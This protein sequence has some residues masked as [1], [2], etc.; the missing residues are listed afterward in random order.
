MKDT[1]FLLPFVGR[2]TESQYLQDVLEKTLNSE[3]RCVVIEGD[4]G[5]GKT[6]FLKEFKNSI[7]ST[8]FQI[9]AG[10]GIDGSGFLEPF[11][12]MLTDYFDRIDNRSQ[13]IARYLRP[14]DVANLALLSPQLLEWFPFEIPKPNEASRDAV[15]GSL[16][17]FFKNLARLYPL[18][19][20]IDDAHRLDEYALEFLDYL[21][22][23]IED[24]PVSVIVGL[25][26]RNR[27]EFLPKVSARRRLER[28]VLNPLNQ[29]MIREALYRLFDHDPPERFLSWLSKVSNGNPFFIE[30]ILRVLLKKNLI[31]YQ[32]GTWEIRDYYE[33]FPLPDT[34]VGFTRDRLKGFNR[35]GLRFL[36]AAAILGEEFSLTDMEKLLKDFSARRFL[37]TVHRLKLEGVLEEK[38]E[39]GYRFHHPFVREVLVQDMDRNEKRNL[40][41]TIARIIE[42]L[43]PERIDEIAA[44]KTLE[45]TPEEYTV[46]LVGFLRTVSSTFLSRQN[47]K[48]AKEYLRLARRVSTAIPSFSEKTRLEIDGQL[49]VLIGLSGEELPPVAEGE[50]LIQ[51]LLTVGL[52]RQ[53]FNIFNIYARRLIDSLR[54]DEARA[55]IAVALEVLGPE[56]QIEQWRLRYLR[57]IL[58]VKQGRYQEAET[59]GQKLVHD[60]DPKISPLGCWFAT[61]LLGG[62]AF[63]YGNLETAQK[64]YEAALQIAEDAGN[65]DIRASSCGNLSLVL[66]ERGEIDRAVEY[67][68]KNLDVVAELGDEYKQAVAHNF[69][70]SCALV[71]RDFGR[72]EVHAQRFRILAQRN[73]VREQILESGLK[74]FHIYFEQK[75]LK[76]AK[77]ELLDLSP[78]KIETLSG[79]HQVELLT[80]Q[81]MIAL[82]EGSFAHAVPIFNSA[83]AVAEE[84]NLSLARGRVLTERGLCLLRQGKKAAARKDFENAKK[85]FIEKKAL[86]SLARL[87]TSFGAEWDG[88]DKD[89]IFVQGLEYLKAMRLFALLREVGNRIKKKEFPKSAIFLKQVLKPTVPEQADAELLN[90]FTFGGLIVEDPKLKE[91]LPEK[92]W[93]SKK[94][95]ELLGLLLVFSK[96]KGATREILSSYLWPEM[97]PKE[98]QNNFHV[99]LSHLRKVLGSDGIICEEP[100]YKLDSGKFRVDY[101][102]FEQCVQEFS[103][104]KVQGKF[105]RAEEVA[106]RALK[107]YQ[108]DFLPEMYS[109]PI[110]DEQL[111]LK[112]Q[113]KELLLWLA[114]ISKE[115]LAWKE[116]LANSQR[117]LQIDPTDERA[118][119][120]VMEALDEQGD[121]G[122]AIKHYARLKK[123]L[124]SELGVEPESITEKL[125]NSLADKEL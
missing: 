66:R 57:C 90:I 125:Y 103:L 52:K 74:W 60:I 81:G 46:E 97:G 30:E 119:R 80:S 117:L 111:V 31:S 42:S 88:K 108:G 121:K 1:V 99:T 67:A 94:A 5:I 58:A 114:E 37:S 7:E 71:Q 124:K 17:N 23:R 101:F 104:F 105:H 48:K 82:A 86:S 85:I 38:K 98:A 109:L 115:R 32:E 120:L 21:G 47:S 39:G 10:N 43:H 64:Y 76:E 62:V 33:D 79:L 122:G 83:F 26:S 8:S 27:Q 11:G 12:T 9:F 20:I 41:R 56:E 96:R 34:I 25:R 18:A 16:F 2:D 13:R 54:F 84:N 15:Y 112:R 113:V 72:A 28:L 118:H 50:D 3:G 92:V 36:K 45:L 123:L 22:C 40:H 14:E 73:N 102:E 100:F 19:L 69:L 35:D 63:S 95:K 65:Q 78:F 24:L 44:H 107:F 87:L 59:E 53:A 51:K 29:E 116:V 61:N 77:K 68:R 75:K 93:G 106:H 49:M 6:R 55:M 70:A 110:D 89:D 4:I 91:S